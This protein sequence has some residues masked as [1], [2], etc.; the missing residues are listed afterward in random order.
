MLAEVLGV[1]E[2]FVFCPGIAL[3]AIILFNS[4]SMSDSWLWLIF[5]HIS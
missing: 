3:K 5:A 2:L 4:V 1:T